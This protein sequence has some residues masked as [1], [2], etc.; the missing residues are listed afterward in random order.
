MNARL[1]GPVT[2]GI[3]LVASVGVAWVLRPLLLVIVP[4]A[5]YAVVTWPLVRRLRRHLPPPIAAVLANA[6]L[7]GVLA[8][9]AILF[10]PILYAQALQLFAALPDAAVRAVAA[11]PVGVRDE[12]GR[13]AGQID[14]S[15]LSWSREIFGASVRLVRSTTAILG[16]ILLIPIL[17]TYLQLDASRYLRALE[18]IVPIEKHD[19]LHRTIAEMYGVFDRFV[20]AQLFV[21]GV[22]GLL[23][24]LVLQL[25]GIPFALTI[26]ILTAAI[27]LIPY[28]GGIAAILPTVVLALAS[29]SLGKALVAVAAIVAVFAFEAQILSPHFIGKSTRLPASMVVLLLLVGGELFGPLG[30]YLAVPVAAMV[31][32]ALVRSLD[33]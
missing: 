13:L 26:G 20:R 12:I 7:A 33:E 28:L 4:T 14:V 1:R 23:V 30:L 32:V 9:I 21:S 27:D 31:R 19:K 29:G 18:A 16:A 24:F 5:L 6:A 15:V 22:V 25:L 3:L 2:I 17:A 8:G 10:G 11:L